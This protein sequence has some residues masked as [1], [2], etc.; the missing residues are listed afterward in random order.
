MAQS[1]IYCSHVPDAPA[2]EPPSIHEREP[3]QAWTYQGEHGMPPRAVPIP[4]SATQGGRRE[5]REA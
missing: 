4:G 5:A 3:S 2:Q 1:I